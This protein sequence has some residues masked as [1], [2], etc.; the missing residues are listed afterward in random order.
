MWRAFGRRRAHRGAEVRT[1]VTVFLTK[2]KSFLKNLYASV[3]KTLR[4]FRGRTAA[5]ARAQMCRR[6]LKWRRVRASCDSGGRETAALSRW[7]LW[8][9]NTRVSLSAATRAA[10]NRITCYEAPSITDQKCRKRRFWA[11]NAG[12]FRGFPGVSASF[13]GFLGVSKTFRS[14]PSGPSPPEGT[15]VRLGWMVG[16]RRGCL[17]VDAGAAASSR[18]KRMSGLVGPVRSQRSE[19]QQ[20]T[21]CWGSTS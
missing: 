5:S 8:K 15:Q 13:G 18:R 20:A 14:V 21:Q 1:N 19:R 11:K 4:R 16:W 12:G 17:Q 3:L 10:A 6:I 7:D 2:F 9:L